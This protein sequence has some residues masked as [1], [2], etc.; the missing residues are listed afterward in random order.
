MNTG[1]SSK[2]FLRIPSFYPQNSL[3]RWVLSWSLILQI[4]DVR[5]R[6]VTPL[7][8]EMASPWW[9]WDAKLGFCCWGPQCQVDIQP[10]HG[11]GFALGCGMEGTVLT[12]RGTQSGMRGSRGEERG[13]GGELIWRSNSW[14]LPQFG[15]GNRHS[16]SGSTN[17]TLIRWTQR[18]LHQDTLQCKIPGP[19]G[20]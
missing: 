9:S 17:I 20:F 5:P 1:N 8:R 7:L 14:K 12:P 3:V 11:S 15:K 19:D 18:S 6:E 16:I 10:H 4:R 13:K 2:C